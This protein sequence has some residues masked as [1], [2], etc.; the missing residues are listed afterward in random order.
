M[1]RISLTKG[2][3]ATVDADDFDRLSEHAW[4][5]MED[6]RT[7]YAARAEAGKLIRMHW[8]VLGVYP[9]DLIDHRNGDGLDNRKQ[10]LRRATTTQ[11]GQ[12]RQ[13]NA[14]HQYKG[15]CFHKRDK[16][17][18]ASIKIPEREIYLGYHD[19]PEAAARAYDTAALEHFG[20]FANLNFKSP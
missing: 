6:E 4:F 10:N 7:N 5:V 17:W 19:T 16:K 15:I 13:P 18:Q 20:E 11:N 12:N 3:F 2:Y 14:G 1:N 8:E 9:P